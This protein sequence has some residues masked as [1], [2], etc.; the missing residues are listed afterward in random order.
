MENTT[1]NTNLLPFVLQTEGVCGLRGGVE[2]IHPKGI[3][4]VLIPREQSQV[5]QGEGKI[6]TT[7]EVETAENSR[8]GQ[9][10]Q[11]STNKKAISIKCYHFILSSAIQGSSRFFKN[12]FSN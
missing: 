3:K 1:V 5:R 9:R 11:T 7:L 2:G 8:T 4:N 10:C 12:T 6:D